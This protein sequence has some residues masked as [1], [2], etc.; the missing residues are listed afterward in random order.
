MSAIALN[1]IINIRLEERELR[2]F[3]WNAIINEYENRTQKKE[4]EEE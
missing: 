1:S 2:S 4:L 3:I